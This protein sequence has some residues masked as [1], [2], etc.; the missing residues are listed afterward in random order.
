MQPPKSQLPAPVKSHLAQL[1]A[2]ALQVP[3]DCFKVMLRVVW[4]TLQ[5]REMLALLAEQVSALASVQLLQAPSERAKPGGQERQVEATLL[6]SKKTAQ[7]W[8][9]MAHCRMAPLS[10]M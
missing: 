5:V 8:Q 10:R 9:L 4:P 7:V 6:A 2:Q 3:V 1:S